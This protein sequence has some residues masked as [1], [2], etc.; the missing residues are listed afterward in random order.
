MTLQRPGV[1]GPGRG[2][3]QVLVRSLPVTSSRWPK[4]HGNCPGG[5]ATSRGSNSAGPKGGAHSHAFPANS[6]GAPALLAQPP[7][8]PSGQFLFRGSAKTRAGPG[9]RRAQL[10]KRHAGFSPSSLRKPRSQL[11][12]RFVRPA[13]APDSPLFA[14]IEEQ[15][16]QEAAPQSW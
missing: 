4:D 12:R 6:T 3:S 7:P 16:G 5:D 1:G 14:L 9:C 13:P 15:V 10:Y 2:V 8:K 11:Q